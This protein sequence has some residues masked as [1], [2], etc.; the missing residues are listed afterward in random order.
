M[1]GVILKLMG[2]F[3]FIKIAHNGQNLLSLL[4]PSICLCHPINQKGLIFVY[5]NCEKSSK[6]HISNLYANGTEKFQIIL[7]T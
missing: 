7:S 2:L 4:I 1:K 6:R 3:Y 5:K